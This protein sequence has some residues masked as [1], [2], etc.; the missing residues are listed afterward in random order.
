ML[1]L[2]MVSEVR[3]GLQGAAQLR[4]T[5]QLITHIGACE[6]YLICVC[7]YLCIPCHCTIRAEMNA[8]YL[9]F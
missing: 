8:E 6:A 9:S 5:L 1:K 3:H 4:K 7:S 2:Y